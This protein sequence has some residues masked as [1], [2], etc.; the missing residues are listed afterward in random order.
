M[1]Q[2]PEQSA[3]TDLLYQKPLQFGIHFS[4]LIV[5]QAN[6]GGLVHVNKQ[7]TVGYNYSRYLPKVGDCRWF[8]TTRHKRSKTI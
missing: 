1:T 7:P 5:I 2:L 3:E 8:S 4:S 6:V